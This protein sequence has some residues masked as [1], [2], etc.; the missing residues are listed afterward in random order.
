MH[1]IYST[2]GLTLVA[3][4]GQNLCQPF[5][6]S[7]QQ[8]GASQNLDT[9]QKSKHMLPLKI[10]SCLFPC[11]VQQ[12][13]PQAQVVSVAL[14]F[15]KIHCSASILL[16]FLSSASQTQFTVC[17]HFKRAAHFRTNFSRLG[18]ILLKVVIIMYT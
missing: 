11:K 18:R 10:S 13:V 1:V 2:R 15:I 7:L 14:A 4:A 6:L 9:V 16:T 5:L 3:L 8:D 17:C 12:F